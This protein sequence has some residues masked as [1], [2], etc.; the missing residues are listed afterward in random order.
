MIKLNLQTDHCQDFDVVIATGSNNSSSYFE[1][2]FGK[3]R[4]IIRKNRNS[5][6]IID[7]TETAEELRSL[8]D[9]IFSYFGLGCRNVSKI[10]L[11]EGYD[12]SKLTQNWETFAGIY[13]TQ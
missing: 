4:N 5:V 2:Y 6:A 7:G 12:L 13:Q 9:D 10:Y 8:G 11:P 1:Y 3:Y